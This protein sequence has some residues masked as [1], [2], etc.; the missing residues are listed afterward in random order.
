MYISKD[1]PPYYKKGDTVFAS[2]NHDKTILDT[3]GRIIPKSI[4]QSQPV[5]MENLYAT[6]VVEEKKEKPKDEHTILFKIITASVVI[7]T[8]GFLIHMVND[9][10]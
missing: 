2:A 5:V 4:L 10:K 3:F 8:L 6:A 7:M 9:K 1:F